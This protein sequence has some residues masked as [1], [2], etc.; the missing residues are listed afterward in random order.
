MFNKLSEQ[1]IAA[2]KD[3]ELGHNISRFIDIRKSF[4]KNNF[5]VDI[6]VESGK[7]SRILL[8]DAVDQ[9]NFVCGID[10]IKDPGISDLIANP[11]YIFLKKDSVTAGKEW[12]FT[13]PN[14]VF[15][16]SIHA[17]EQVL[18]ELHYWW[19]LLNVGGWAIF[20]DTQWEGYIHKANHCCAGK[21]PGNSGLGYDF[22]AGTAWETP[23][24]AVLKFFNIPS[25]NYE[26]EFITS[27]H[28]PDSLGMT[29]IHKKKDKDF[30]AAISNWSEIESNRQKL[31]ACF[32]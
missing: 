25:L 32:M 12:R 23:D 29:F 7:S 6:G 17:K 4:G 28:M 11:N 31:L 10:P 19:D 8:D 22:Y 13:K 21:K 14:I 1:D 18:M 9:N 27:I 20:H 5:F 15:I 2:L 24:K 3:G 30:K 26:D 16:D